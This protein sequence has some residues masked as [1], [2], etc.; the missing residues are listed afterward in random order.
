MAWGR[1]ICGFV[2]LM[3]KSFSKHPYFQIDPE[4]DGQ[5]AGQ[6]VLLCILA[7]IN[8]FSGFLFAAA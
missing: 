7:V 4:S 6:P 8:A 5:I 3:S 1:V 2:V